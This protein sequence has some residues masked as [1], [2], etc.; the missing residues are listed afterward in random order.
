MIYSETFS[1]SPVQIKVYWPCPISA[2][3]LS[4]SL[5]RRYLNEIVFGGLKLFE[6]WTSAFKYNIIGDALEITLVNT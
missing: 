4:L 5:G 6:V 3:F 2:F 1:W